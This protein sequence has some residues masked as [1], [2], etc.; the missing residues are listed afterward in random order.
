LILVEMYSCDSYD[1][2]FNFK[3]NIEARES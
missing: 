3:R 1:C 2:E